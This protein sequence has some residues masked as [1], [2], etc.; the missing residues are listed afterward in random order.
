M[1]WINW[2]SDYAVYL[3]AILATLIMLLLATA[4]AD[5]EIA[6]GSLTY[7]FINPENASE[8]F[9]MQL[10]SDGALIINPVV[11]LRI[12]SSPRAQNYRA[13]TAFVGLNSIGRPMAGYMASTGAETIYG[14]F[15]IVMGGYMQDN[16]QFLAY[17]I[18]PYTTG[19]YKGFGLVPIGGL[20]YSTIGKIFMHLLLTPAVSCV[21]MGYRF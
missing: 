18:Q 8:A 10:S 7:H 1:L 16:R 15:G 21:N 6:V 13:H 4:H 2:T 17:N 9:K 19:T 20:E 12:L 3:G 14:R 5:T 11:G